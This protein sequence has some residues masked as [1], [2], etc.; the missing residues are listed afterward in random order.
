MRVALKDERKLSWRRWQATTR[1]LSEGSLRAAA[2][3]VGAVLPT[4]AA[5][6]LPAFCGAGER[7]ITIRDCSD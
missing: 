2:S 5:A 6:L 1:E 7:S 4:N 3:S